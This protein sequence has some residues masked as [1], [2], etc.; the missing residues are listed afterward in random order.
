MNIVIRALSF[1]LLDDY[2][3]FFDTIA[4]KDHKEWSG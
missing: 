3:D 1:E 2:M 4:F